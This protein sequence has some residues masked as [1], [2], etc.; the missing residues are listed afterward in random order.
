MNLFGRKK[1]PAAPGGPSDPAQTIL[2][3]RSTVETLEKRQVHLDK[4]IEQQTKEAKEKMGKKDKRGAL[5]CLKRKK[6]FE[7]EL[8]KLAG[9]RWTLEQQIVQLE[10]T[11]TTMEVARNM[12]YGKEAMRAARGGMDAD[13]VADTMDDIREEM[14]EANAIGDL[15]GEGLG[16]DY[17]DDDELLDELDEVGLC[18]CPRSCPWPFSCKCYKM[19]ALVFTNLTHHAA[20]S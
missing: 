7:N 10:A 15:L 20:S 3:L 4:K 2:K 12:E 18:P 5:Y 17:E 9:S 19:S 6:M 11:V 1:S 13:D 16:N 14:D 8:T